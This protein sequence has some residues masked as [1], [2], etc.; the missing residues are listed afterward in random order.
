MK[1]CK[2]GHQYP[3]DKKQCPECYKIYKKQYGIDNKEQ[4]QPYMTQYRLDNKESIKECKQQWEQDHKEHKK[5]QAQLYYLD[6][7]E[8]IKHIKQEYLKT[9]LY[10]HNAL[11]AK[12]R[13][14]KLNQTPKWLTKDQLKQMEHYYETAKWVESILGESIVVDHIIPVQGKNVSGLHVPWNLQL[15][16]R[17]DNARKGNNIA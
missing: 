14:A 10:Q 3:E 1:T 9:H 15:L 17:E 13:A 5:Q 12:R 6:H 8:H 16:T 11:S 7:K 4:I 2:K